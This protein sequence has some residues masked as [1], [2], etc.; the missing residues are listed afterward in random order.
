VLIFPESHALRACR[1]RISWTLFR[2]FETRFFSAGL[3]AASR[4]LLLIAEGACFSPPFLFRFSQ[5]RSRVLFKVPYLLSSTLPSARILSFVAAAYRA[6][7]LPESPPS[8]T[9]R[10]SVLPFLSKS[11][12]L[13]LALT[14]LL[15]AAKPQ[16]SLS[17]RARASDYK[18][19][20]QPPIPQPPFP[21]L[22][23]LTFEPYFFLTPFA[24]L[25]SIIS[26]SEF[27][28]SHATP[29]FSPMVLLSTISSSLVPL[30]KR[31]V[32]PLANAFPPFGLKRADLKAPHPSSPPGPVEKSQTWA[33]VFCL[34]PLP[35]SAY[36]PLRTPLKMRTSP[37]I[38]AGC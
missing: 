9:R 24:S 37:A 16:L 7:R 29:V 11:L 23:F 15:A 6:F 25:F 38:P 5:G 19:T 4:S 21:R 10:I 20:V 18:A 34:F 32:P 14:L 31:L 17:S 26:I 30:G 22:S 36:F 35:L 33:P 28:T 1:G 3:D 27:W 12:V 8:L 13:S 2:R